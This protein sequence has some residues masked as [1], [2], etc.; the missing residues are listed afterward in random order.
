[1]EKLRL[2]TLGDIEG[3]VALNHTFHLDFE[4][5]YWDDAQWVESQVS[6]RAYYVLEQEGALLAALCLIVEGSDVI[7]GTLC[8]RD[9]RR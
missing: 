9:Q 2:A 8:C 7:G 5:F 4:G 3:I 1:M 6:N